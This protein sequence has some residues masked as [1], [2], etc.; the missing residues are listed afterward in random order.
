MSPTCL[1]AP[2]PSSAAPEAG[3][4]LGRVVR[5]EPDPPWGSTCSAACGTAGELGRTRAQ[6][7]RAMRW[8][9]PRPH[10]PIRRRTN[11]SRS[12]Q[13]CLRSPPERHRTP[14]LPTPV[15]ARSRDSLQSGAARDQGERAVRC[16]HTA[17]RDS[18]FRSAAGLGL[19]SNNPEPPRSATSREAIR[20]PVLR[21]L[22]PRHIPN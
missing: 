14:S 20:L 16:Q 5:D 17:T 4:L 19:C 12:H 21:S 18:A 22:V 1:A 15:P 13:G 11:A 10:P 9:L 3:E 6:Q 7:T 8:S 2:K